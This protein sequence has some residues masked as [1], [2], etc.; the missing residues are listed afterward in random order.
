[1]LAGRPAAP[2]CLADGFPLRLPGSKAA[3]E[4]AC[5]SMVGETAS[6][7][8]ALTPDVGPLAQEWLCADSG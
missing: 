1:M 2:G 4:L 6:R 5:K 3:W 7:K 8:W